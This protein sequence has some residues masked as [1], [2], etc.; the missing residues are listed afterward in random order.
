MSGKR[1][2]SYEPGHRPKF[3]VVVDQTEECDRAVYF[4]AR[5]VSRIGATLIMLWVIDTTD[6]PTW[7][8]VADVMTAEAQAEAETAL[9]RQAAQARTLAGIEPERL[10]RVGIKAEEIVKLIEEDQDISILVLAAG[11]GTE[12]PGPLV[13]KVANS[14]AAFPIPVAIVPGGLSNEEIDALA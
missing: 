12:G 2:R 11:T 14:S 6:F 1:R 7:L 13:S 8:G 3:L 10:I 9:E 5:R 4:A